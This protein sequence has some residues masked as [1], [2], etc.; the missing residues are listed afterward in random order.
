MEINKPA[1][2]AERLR[3]IM[4]ERGLKQADIL[5]LCAPLC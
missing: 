2:T 4:Q 3:Q 5:R 1:T